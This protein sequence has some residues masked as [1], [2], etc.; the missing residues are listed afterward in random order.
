M[1]IIDTESPDHE[2]TRAAAERAKS[3]GIEIIVVAVGKNV[4]DEEITSIASEPVSSHK[5]TLADYTETLDLKH[6]FYALICP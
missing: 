4:S 2:K 1:V 5:I 3:A 6:K